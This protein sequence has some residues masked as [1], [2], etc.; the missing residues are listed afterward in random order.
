MRKASLGTIFLTVF[1]DLLGFGLVVPFLP[2]VARDLGAS[3]VVATMLGAAYSLM[4]FLFIPFWGRLSDRIGRRPVLLV[5]ILANAIGMTGLALADSMPLLFAA[6]CFSGAATAN[7]AV[8]QAYIADITTPA[9]RARGMGLIGMAF[10]LG[11]ILGPFV[12]G[13]LGQIEVFGRQGP[14][15]ALVAAG[16]SLVNLALAAAFLPE[17]RPRDQASVPARAQ[18]RS[19]LDLGA[20]REVIRVRGLGLAALLGFVMTF[21]FSGLEVTYRLFTMDAFGMSVAGTGYVFVL[22][23]FVAALTQGGLIGR[24]TPRF[25]E[26]R[27]LATGAGILSAGFLLV[28]LSAL[29]ARGAFA[30]TLFLLGSSLVALGNGLAIPSLSSYTSQQAGPAIQGMA[31]GV[32]Q[33]LGALARATGPLLGGAAYDFVSIMG[34]YF[35]GAVGIAVAAVAARRL[36][37]LGTPS[38]PW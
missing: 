1:L 24:L 30:M 21:F 20:L 4:Q 5:S 31:L 28:G 34:P 10:G 11:F 2:G 13:V 32:M 37:A 25:G 26:T 17:S 8:A 15:A 16:L 18:R 14:V 6:R 3:D 23:G 12:G 38:A 19:P 9:T 27:L 22:I 7:I 36:P 29:P 35:L 33:S